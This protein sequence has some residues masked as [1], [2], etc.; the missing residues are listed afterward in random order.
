MVMSWL[1]SL[2]GLE[3]LIAACA[4]SYLTATAFFFSTRLSRLGQSIA[5]VVASSVVLGMPLLV[6]SEN[7]GLRLIGTLWAICLWVKVYDLYVAP[8]QGPGRF[9]QWLAHLP[10][11]LSIVWRKL[12][13]EPRYTLTNELTRLI[14]GAAGFV[15]GLMI[16]R[17]LWNVYWLDQ[18]FALEHAAKVSVL[19]LTLTAGAYAL[20]AGM[21]LA[22]LPARDAMD[23]PFI[24]ATPADFWRRYNRP[25]QQFLY[26]DIFKRV[27]GW[28]YPVRATLL[29][30]FISG[31][32]H[33]YVF[34]IPIGAIQAYQMTFFMLQGVAVASTIR[35][36]PEGIWRPL[37]TMLTLTFMLS[38]AV[39][40]FASFNG[41]MAFYSPSFPSWLDDWTVIRW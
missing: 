34:A 41:I 5:V 35:V 22:R 31:L 16:M 29:T 14:L 1:A 32:I 24:A 10:S 4:F 3:G 18:A 12:H 28:R 38:T 11:C 8:S 2:S 40:F 37:A 39:L 27:G 36:R 6:P 13:L 21:R 15:A 9:I 7:R 30:F 25:A 19:I 33:E 23:W 20:A 17:Q 26:E